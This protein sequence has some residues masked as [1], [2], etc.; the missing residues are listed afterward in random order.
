MR[1]TRL[2]VLF[3]LI[4]VIIINGSLL[5]SCSDYTGRYENTKTELIDNKHTDNG[6]YVNIIFSI[7]AIVLSV[8]SIALS[9]FLS[10]SNKK[11]SFAQLYLEFSNNP[12][13]KRGYNVLL[14]YSARDEVYI[15]PKKHMSIITSYFT[16]LEM[17]TNEY[18]NMKMF[19]IGFESINRIITKDVY[20]AMLSD[21][22]EQGKYKGLFKLAKREW[23]KQH[24]HSE[25]YNG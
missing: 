21:F 10:Y 17:M 3:A 11:D 2:I 7:I 19:K 18:G 6:G 24:K 9:A 25:V 4:M 15:I 23:K 5:C 16:F 13:Y 22:N 1:K 20:F 12:L 14:K 8:F